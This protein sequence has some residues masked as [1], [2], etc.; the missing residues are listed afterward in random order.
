MEWLKTAKNKIKCGLNDSNNK[1][2]DISILIACFL[3]SFSNAEHS[4]TGKLSAKIMFERNLRTI[5]S[6]VRRMPLKNLV[7]GKRHEENPHKKKRKMKR[8]RIGDVLVK[9]Y[10]AREN[11]WMKAEVTVFNCAN[12]RMYLFGKGI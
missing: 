5:L 11:K 3:I 6:Q 12:C 8:C 7:A 1:D 2:V 4:T 9:D 10:G